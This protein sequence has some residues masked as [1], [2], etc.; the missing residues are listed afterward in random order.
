MTD[1]DARSAQ[2]AE[3]RGVPRT[4][5][6]ILSDPRWDAAPI[7]LYDLLVAELGPM[8]AEA[9]WMSACRLCDN[10]AGEGPA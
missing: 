4:A 2:T 8:S 5:E 6:A 9:A 3:T 10:L 7:E 1:L